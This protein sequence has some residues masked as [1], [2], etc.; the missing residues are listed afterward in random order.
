LK[1]FKKPL[2]KA[3]RKCYNDYSKREGDLLQIKRVTTKRQ[4]QKRRKEK[5]MS[6]ITAMTTREFL[7]A[8]IEGKVDSAV[9]EK[10][11]SMLE[12]L[13]ARNEKRKSTDSKEKKEAAARR[14]L[15][16]NFLKEQTE[17][18]TR[19]T[20]AGVLEMEPSKVT[21]ACTALVKEGLVNKS[22]VKVDKT[23]KVAYSIA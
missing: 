1:N 2:D 16:L 12:S 9:I 11:Q 5:I 8:V 14:E 17:P 18:L 6:T 19:D 3:L 13:D 7:N 10:A 22:K 20:I 21:G 15:V 4:A 23:E